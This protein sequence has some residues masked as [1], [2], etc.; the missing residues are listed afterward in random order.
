MADDPTAVSVDSEQ[1]ESSSH[2]HRQLDDIWD[3]YKKI[4]L[5][6]EEHDKWHRWYDARCRYCGVRHAG[7]PVILRKHTAKCNKADLGAQTEALQGQQKAGNAESDDSNGSSSGCGAILKYVDKV[8]ITANQLKH[9][10]MLLAVTFIMTGWSFATVENP[11]FASFISHVRPNFELPS[12]LQSSSLGVKA[13]QLA[14]ELSCCASCRC[15]SAAYYLPGCR[16]RRYQAQA[17]CPHAE[18]SFGVSLD[19][20]ARWLVK[21]QNGVHLLLECCLSQPEGHLAESRRFVRSVTHWRDVVRLIQI[22]LQL[23]C[24]CCCCY[25]IDL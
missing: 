9:W 6:T 5:T 10:R 16:S 11:H 13:C 15:L 2:G 7:K 19:S 14:S 24:C 4:R 8:K 18:C 22:N 20:D 21:S 1:A 25:H 23:A 17:A 12:R 3:H